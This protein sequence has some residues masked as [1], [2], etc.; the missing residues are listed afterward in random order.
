MLLLVVTAFSMLSRIAK[1]IVRV[2]RKT[3]ALGEELLG[4][5]FSGRHT[6]PFQLSHL[7]LTCW[8]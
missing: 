7:I 6:Q 5:S 4:Q 8:K 1:E 2:F 3:D